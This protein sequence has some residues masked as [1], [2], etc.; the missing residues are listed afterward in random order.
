MTDISLAGSSPM[1]QFAALAL[2]L[3]TSSTALAQESAEIEI[4]LVRQL[5]LRGWHDLAR[6]RI[7]LLSK[8]PDPVL[9]M[10]LPV[11]MVQ[12]DIAEARHKSLDERLALYAVAGKKLDELK[13]R[14]QG[15]PE[16]ALASVL[17]ARLTSLQAQAL[18]SKAMREETAAERH[19][20]ARPVESMFMQAI[21][22]L[23]AAIE[24]LK[25]ASA[26]ASPLQKNVIDQE[27]RQARLDVAMN[28]YNQARTYLDRDKLAVNVERT[29]AMKRA[30]EAFESLRGDETSEIGYLATA[31]LMRCGM[32]L[33]NPGDVVNH[34]NAIMKKKRTQPAIE[35]A[36][37]L[38]RYFAI[39][40][41]TPP[42]P[43]DPDAVGHNV[44]KAS[45]KLSALQRL[46]LVQAEGEAW[47]KDYPDHLRTYEG[48]GVLFELGTAYY[49]E[50][51][52][53]K[54]PKLAGP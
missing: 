11:E 12:L 16:A 39:L 15:K 44:L 49:S 27:V 46:H 22:E 54:N 28:L 1:K 5:R 33:T 52:G 14:R 25:T 45:Q 24:S 42:R 48:E 31:W 23:A 53:E 34:Y 37:R 26:K 17:H 10:S 20:K 40:D 8:R 35:P 30:Q 32:E 6:E 29:A 13:L 41:L 9:A 4:E 36:V 38:V 21:D 3:L 19:A 51:I 50:G 18:L 7:N 47:I 2:L 43:G